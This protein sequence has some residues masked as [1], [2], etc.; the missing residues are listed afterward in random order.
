MSERMGKKKIS[1]NRLKEALAEFP[2]AGN[3]PGIP[4][5]LPSS[6]NTVRAAMLSGAI[7]T[8]ASAPSKAAPPSSVE[9][10]LK[11]YE[12][13]GASLNTFDI[14]ELALNVLHEAAGE[15]LEGQL[16]VAQVTIARALSGRREFGDGTISGTIRKK[17]QFSWTRDPLKAYGFRKDERALQNIRQYLNTLLKGTT[18]ELALQKLSALTGIAE[19]CYFYKRTDWDESKMSEATARLFARLHVH[20]TIGNHTFYLE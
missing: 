1:L 10:V 9:Q 4:S 14:E 7:I 11:E 18:K 3:T 19:N 6:K 8:A 15:P 20:K 5:G 16:A 2:E 17:N 13:T 12:R